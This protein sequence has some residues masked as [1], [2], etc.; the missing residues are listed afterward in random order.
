MNHLYSHIRV[1]SR[2][3]QDLSRPSPIKS[4]V[5]T[6]KLAWCIKYLPCKVENWNSISSTHMKSQQRRAGYHCNPST[7]AV[8][9]EAEARKP[10]SSCKQYR[11]RNMRDPASKRSKERTDSKSCPLSSTYVP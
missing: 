3:E 6:S 8:R 1:G 7:P 4:L 2:E 10:L 11:S 9:C 5:G